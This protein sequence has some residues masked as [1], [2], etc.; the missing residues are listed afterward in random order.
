MLVVRKL[1]QKLAG[2]RWVTKRETHIVLR[3][4]LRVATGTN[5]RLRTFEKLR[6]MTANAGSVTGKVCNVGK[7]SYLF[8]VGRRNL[9]ASVARALM[10]FSCVGETG[11]VDGGSRRAWG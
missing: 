10:F 4:Y 6:T 9:V 5:D 1:D 8:P 11:V 3:R 2:S 7:V